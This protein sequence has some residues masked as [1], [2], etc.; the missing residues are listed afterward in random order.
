MSAYQLGAERETLNGL[1]QDLQNNNIVGDDQFVLT[2]AVT[3]VQKKAHLENQR[4]ALREAHQRGALRE[5]HQR[6]AYTALDASWRGF[7]ANTPNVHVRPLLVD[8]AVRGHIINDER[9]A[10]RH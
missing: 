3:P 4:E 7:W 6:E 8:W 10:W 9:T 5:A 2:M 1:L